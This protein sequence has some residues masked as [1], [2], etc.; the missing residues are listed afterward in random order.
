MRNILIFI[1][2]SF[3]LIP[4]Y[5]N[6][7]KREFDRDKWEDLRDDMDYKEFPEEQVKKEQ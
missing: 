1:L 2:L 6:D 3:V 7:D 5:G 4:S